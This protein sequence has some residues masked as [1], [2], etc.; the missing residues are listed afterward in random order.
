MLDVC[1][2]SIYITIFIKIVTKKTNKHLKLRKKS[3]VK[4]SEFKD[5]SRKKVKLT[6]EFKICYILDLSLSINLIIILN[7][8]SLIFFFYFLIN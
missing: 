3:Q 2:Y 6:F 5:Y 7:F 8:V 1:F 4:F